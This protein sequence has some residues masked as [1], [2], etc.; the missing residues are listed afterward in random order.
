M[1]GSDVERDDY[2][3]NEDDRNDHKMNDH[4]KR[5]IDENDEVY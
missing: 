1:S 5:I 3:M 2:E 4:E